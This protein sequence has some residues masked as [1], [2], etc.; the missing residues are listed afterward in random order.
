[1]HLKSVVPRPLAAS[2]AAALLLTSLGPMAPRP[3]PG[4]VKVRASETTHAVDGTQDF[5]IP[6]NSTHVAV[7]WLGSPD[8]KVTAAFST[9]G[10]VFLE[11]AE[12]EV[13]DAGDGPDNA[14]SGETYGAL[15]G[16]DGISVVRVSADRPLAKVS[17]LAL[18]AAD[19]EPLPL[20]LGAQAAGGTTIPTIISRRA[21][22]ADESARH[23]GAGDEFWPREYFPVQKLVVHHT[24]GRNADPDPAA[25]VRAI[26]YYHAVSRRWADIGYNYLI[27]EAGRIYEGRY[28][29]DFWNGANPSADNQAGLGVAGGH[30]KYH[31]PGSMGIALLGTFTSQSPTP[32]ARASLVRLLAWAAAK[33]HIDPRGNST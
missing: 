8:A 6:S 23:D 11:P 28:A 12:V 18:D 2:I 24:A 29:R 7:H 22:G 27:D 19:P 31:N 15:M 21:W 25:T 26:Y 5:T 13:E 10:S 17:V 32:A 33:Y 9:D 20:G 4:P 3:E 1:M 14:E 30:A 16:V